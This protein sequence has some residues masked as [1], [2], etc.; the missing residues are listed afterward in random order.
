LVV[1][2]D[3]AGGG[4]ITLLVDDLD[5]V[6]GDAAKRGLTPAHCETVGGAGRKASFDDPAGNRITFAEPRRGGR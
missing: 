5:A 2:A 1:D 3:R 4:L 6:V